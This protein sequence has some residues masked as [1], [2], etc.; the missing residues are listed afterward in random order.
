MYKSLLDDLPVL[1]NNYLCPPL[2]TDHEPIQQCL[3]RF[4]IPGQL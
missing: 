4:T 3:V 1:Q 2:R